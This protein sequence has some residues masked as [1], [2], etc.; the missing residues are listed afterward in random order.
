MSQPLILLTGA[1]GFL[2]SW[3]LERLLRSSR[4]VAVLARGDNRGDAC[5]RI[6]T[7]L[8]PFE[9]KRLLPRPRVIDGDLH[10]P[11]CGIRSEDSSWLGNREIDVIHCA[12]SIRFVE[13]AGGEPYRTNVAG[14][15][16]LLSLCARCH[17]RDFHHVSTAYVGARQTPPVFETPVQDT[18]RGENDY[19][20]SKV[21]AE[22]LV[23]EFSDLGGRKIFHRPSIVV[24]DSRTF[25]TTTYHGFYA[26]LQIGATL[27]R[28]H[29]FSKGL[30]EW[31]RSQLGLGELDRK[32]LVPVDWVADQISNAVLREHVPSG[33]YHWT[34][35]E[36]TPAIVMQNAITDA[37]EEYLSNQV[38]IPKELGPSR[39]F[40]DAGG[41][42]AKERAPE[43]SAA[44]REQMS[45][46][47]S[48]FNGDP[49][50]DRTQAE[51]IST[52]CSKLDYAILKKMCWHALDANFGW[53]RP[54]L[55]PPPD[56]SRQ[57]PS[58]GCS[59]NGNSATFTGQH[60]GV[61]LLGKYSPPPFFL[62]NDGTRWVSTSRAAEDC[63]WYVKLPLDA[64][65]GRIKGANDTRHLFEQ[66]NA[67]A[68]GELPSN[69]LAIFDAWIQDVIAQSSS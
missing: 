16:N 51:G 67:I 12:A 66:G 62:R 46:Y 31:F 50:F 10:L 54:P 41:L 30:G 58:L 17:V 2:G 40:K 15:Q 59:V 48:Y 56:H 23:Q 42:I 33:I 3:I 68:L 22:Q 26:P 36:P 45:V 27:A 65:T 43:I 47:E 24:G 53:P 4:C 21:Q 38:E 7:V 52:R 39:E 28:A 63:G 32:N 14:T 57:L 5:Q 20:R 18:T 25:R 64:L 11:D 8:E 9:D 55:V 49:E 61:S 34:H 69:W 19:E 6:E 35:P 60:F 1:T 13:D 44:F 29:G 37:I